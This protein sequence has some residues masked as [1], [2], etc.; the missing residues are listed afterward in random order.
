MNFLL[1]KETVFSSISWNRHHWCP[2]QML[3]TSP[4][5]PI[6]A[7][8]SLLLF[9]ENCVQTKSIHPGSYPLSSSAHTTCLTPLLLRAL[10]LDQESPFQVLPLGNLTEDTIFDL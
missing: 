9:P 1:P 8:N 5:H 3:F 10:L 4:D 6:D 7:N 2:A